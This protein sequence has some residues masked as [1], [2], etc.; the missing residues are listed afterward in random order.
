MPNPYKDLKDHY[1]KQKQVLN[2]LRARQ[3]TIAEKA[4]VKAEAKAAGLQTKIDVLSR[5]E[6]HD[7]EEMRKLEKELKQAA[8]ELSEA[9]INLD[10]IRSLV[11]SEYTKDL[12]QLME[13]TRQQ[14]AHPAPLANEKVEFMDLSNYDNFEKLDTENHHCMGYY[15]INGRH[16][17]LWKSNEEDSMFKDTTRSHPLYDDRALQTMYGEQYFGDKA[18]LQVG[19]PDRGPQEVERRKKISSLQVSEWKDSGIEVE[20]KKIVEIGGGS[21]YLSEEVKNQGG[22]PINVELCKERCES[23]EQRGIPTYNGFLQ[24]G[25]ANEDESLLFKSADIVACY[26]LLE[27]IVN[28]H[29]GFIQ[30]VNAVLKTGG[31]LCIRIPEG[32]EPELHLVDHVNHFS[33]SSL[34]NFLSHFGFEYVERPEGK[35]YSG[36][37]HEPQSEFHT[38]IHPN[39]VTEKAKHPLNTRRIENMTVYFRKTRDCDYSILDKYKISQS[40]KISMKNV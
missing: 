9:R 32:N 25:V 22:H 29:Q 27:H 40:E 2:E 17:S 31:H 6:S 37:F 39:D 15:R 8:V 3:I 11:N 24:S 35:R 7:P 1:L 20:G 23:C 19:I 21:G 13:S 26:D 38:D 33:F 10:E 36:T 4:V 12:G 18:T 34:K 14:M 5:N 30:A 16:F 28:P